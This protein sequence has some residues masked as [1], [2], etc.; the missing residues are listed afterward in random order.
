MNKWSDF[1]LAF[2]CG[3]IFV[4]II[5]LFFISFTFPVY[6]YVNGYLWGLSLGCSIITLSID[7]Y[8]FFKEE[9]KK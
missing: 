6:K 1:L 7:F 8:F 4:C 2:N 9:V 5:L 3:A